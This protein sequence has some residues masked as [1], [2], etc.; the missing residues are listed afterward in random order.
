MKQRNPFF[1]ASSSDSVKQPSFVDREMDRV[2]CVVIGAGAVGLAVGRAMCG[3]GVYTMV[4]EKHSAFGTENS[5][6][7]SEVLHAGL[8]YPVG[9]A[10]ARFCNDGKNKLLTYM[11]DR[12]IPHNQ[13]GKLVIASSAAEI[14]TLHKICKNGAANG[15]N[16]LR[17]VSVD[18]ARV[19][20]PSVS[21]VAAMLSP[22]TGIFDSHT[23]MLNYV[24]DIETTGSDIVYNCE[25]N[26]VSR[27]RIAPTRR[28]AV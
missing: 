8:Y 11:K 12:N 4:L 19:L 15:L 28:E 23:L 14:P 6:R 17:M 2:P 1:S 25:V 20:E 22:F 24:T 5:S 3:A 18:E 27:T 16:D 26:D 13:C 9:S 10:K 7:N 21:C